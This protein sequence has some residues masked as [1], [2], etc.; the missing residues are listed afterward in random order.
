M[1]L[2]TRSLP[3]SL[4]RCSRGVTAVEFAFVLMPMLLLI[5]GVIEFGRALHLRNE[6]A[7]AADAATRQVLL[8]PGTGAAEAA[9]AARAAFPVGTPS[10]LSVTL[11]DT[12]GG[13]RVLSLSYPLNLTIPGLSGDAITLTTTRRLPQ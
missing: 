12:V 10:D 1:T 9:A 3:R 11:A 13:A 8:D 2:R 5:F 6:M 4:I 7:Y